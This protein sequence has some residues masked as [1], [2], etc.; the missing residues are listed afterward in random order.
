[1]KLIAKAEINNGKNIINPGDAFDIDDKTGSML[2]DRGLAVEPGGKVGDV[3]AAPAVDGDDAKAEK[4][5]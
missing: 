4:K 1:M 5:K 3:S 2:M